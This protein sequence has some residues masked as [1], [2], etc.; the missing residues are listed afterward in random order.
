MSASDDCTVRLWD[1]TSKVGA[2][3]GGETWFCDGRLIENA[4][5]TQYFIIQIS[6][7]WNLFIYFFV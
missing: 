7:V 1:V 4:K 3:L 5:V 6:K 2:P